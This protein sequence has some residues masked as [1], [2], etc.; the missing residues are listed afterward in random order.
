M[1]QQYKKIHLIGICGSAMGSVAAMLKDAGY[2]VQGSDNELYPPM[3]DFLAASGI[4]TF[5]TLSPENITGDVDLVVVGNAVARG[6]VEL[7]Y[8]LD[9]K[10]KYV[11]FPEIIREFFIRG[12][13]SIVV[14]GTH[15]KTTTSTIISWILHDAGERVGFLIGG[16]PLNFGRGY[17]CP[18]ESGGYFVIEGDEYDTAFSDKRSKFLHYLPDLL[19]INNLEFDH[20]DIF[21]NLDEIKKSFRHLIKTIPARGVIV[22]NADDDN[23]TDIISKVYSQLVTFGIKNQRADY[24]AAKIV[25]G[26][27]TT[28]FEVV[29]DGKVIINISSPLKGE[30]NVY[31]VL[32]AVAA[33]DSIDFDMNK[34][35]TAIKKFQNV[36][37]RLEIVGEA[38]GV[39]VYDDFAHH[40]TAIKKTISGVKKAHPKRRIIALFE[41]KSNTSRRHFFQNEFA[42]A[43]GDA[44]QVVIGEVYN[45]EKMNATER[46]D[47]YKLVDNI[48]KT[49]TEARYIPDLEELCEF[50]VKSVKS[51]DIILVMSSGS[52]HGVHNKLLTILE[53]RCS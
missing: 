29:K 44:D 47:P 38:G 20:A 24:S 16:I 17:A 2:N 42:T 30:H 40:P 45:Y 37:R 27:D 15:G 35:S 32:G 13:Q 41:P 10:L 21:D 53:E 26:N 14:T 51:G 3:S 36:K 7:E 52:F 39:S 1:R 18:P 4:K 23:V 31:N 19:L 6:N 43:F 25:Y 11:S 46:L 50:V 12:N 48:N 8:V 9:N 49:G 34:F 5:D 33:L 22:A 28:E